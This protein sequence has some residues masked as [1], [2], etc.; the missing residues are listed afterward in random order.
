MRKEVQK[1]GQDRPLVHVCESKDANQTS[2]KP[3]Q[4]VSM[5]KTQKHK[6]L[7]LN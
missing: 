5:L 4:E 3:L 7:S 2:S 6:K 1:T